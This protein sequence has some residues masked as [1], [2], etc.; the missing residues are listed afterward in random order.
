MQARITRRTTMRS[1]K[2]TRDGRSE[3]TR[4]K[5]STHTAKEQNGTPR[6]TSTAQD[7]SHRLHAKRPEP[8]VHAR[9]PTQKRRTKNAN[10]DAAVASKDSSRP[11]T[12]TD[13]CKQPLFSLQRTCTLRQKAR[14]GHQ[15]PPHNSQHSQ[16]ATL[17]CQLPRHD[18][19]GG[20][21][22]R[23]RALFGPTRD[24][25]H[26]S[27]APSRRHR[28][29]RSRQTKARGRQTS[30][31]SEPQKTTKMTGGVLAE[32]VPRKGTAG[33]CNNIHGQARGSRAL[34]QRQVIC[35]FA[36]SS[37]T[38]TFQ[39]VS[40]LHASTL[41]PTRARRPFFSCI[42]GLTFP[43]SQGSRPNQHCMP[44]VCLERPSVFEDI[45]Q[46]RPN[47]P[48]TQ[49]HLTQRAFGASQWG[50]VASNAGWTCGRGTKTRTIRFS[51]KH[52]L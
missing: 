19:K 22:R 5:K 49:A 29:S 44:R 36:V 23:F 39:A 13:L 18:A 27:R 17:V 7:T 9:S 47:G 37:L 32:A 45:Q 21:A 20:T 11:H 50:L 46:L 28:R 38:R 35:S 10:D 33:D 31:A 34:V 26:K 48:T 8:S 16:T 1:T 2:T 6:T 24:R 15:K 4:G 41:T 43:I 14:A 51:F 3:E 30:D 25:L 42:A 52:R 40:P 12:P